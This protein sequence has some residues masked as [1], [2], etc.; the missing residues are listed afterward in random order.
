VNDA[1]DTR[2]AEPDHHRRPR[3]ARQRA[4]P[5]AAIATPPSEAPTK[6]VINP[7]MTYSFTSTLRCNGRE[8]LRGAARAIT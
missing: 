2:T 3:A 1:A 8:G 7:A 4:I 5:H 6:N